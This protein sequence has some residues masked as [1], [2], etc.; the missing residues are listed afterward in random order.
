MAQLADDWADRADQQQCIDVLCAYL[1]MPFPTDVTGTPLPGEVQV[2]ETVVRVI[3]AYLRA[4][5]TTPR[6][7]DSFDFTGGTVTVDQ[8]EFA[9][10]VVT[11]NGVEFRG[12][13]PPEPGPEPVE[14]T[15]G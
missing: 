7:R 4:D 11:R 1:R 12:W 14:E 8:A 15:A 9:D 13:R 3:T 6:P 5:A 10:G 2:R